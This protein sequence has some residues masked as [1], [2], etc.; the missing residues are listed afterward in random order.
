MRCPV[1]LALLAAAGAAAV[2]ALA[3]PAPVRLDYAAP[4]G[5]PAEPE[6]RSIVAAR[7]GADPFTTGPAAQTVR[8]IVERRPGGFAGSVELRDPAGRLVWSRPPLM[9]A[10]CRRLVEVLGGVSIP[11]AID[12]PAASAP[13]A[14][15]APLAVPTMPPVAPPSPAPSP[16]EPPSTR[17]AFRLGARGGLALGLTP[18][19]TA[20]IAVDVGVGWPSFSLALEGGAALPMQ[21]DADA[22]VRLRTSIVSGSLVPCGHY[23]WF[24]GCGLISVGALRAEA[25]NATTPATSTGIFLAAGARAGLEWPIVPAF[26]LRLSADALVN[27]HPL[28][29]QALKGP[30]PAQATLVEAWR[31]GPFAGVL[32]AGFVARFGGS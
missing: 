22:G 11:A 15:P 19:P 7:M 27:L 2:P 3:Q 25:V 28:G 8:V 29:A 4:D 10:D 32:G 1:S 5:C 20:H 26:A 9:D 31:S 14:V 13:P 16:V 24:V 17:P 23:K 6:L 18:T 30:T 21:G 12:G